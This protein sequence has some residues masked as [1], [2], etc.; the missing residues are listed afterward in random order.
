MSDIM[1]DSDIKCI[2]VLSLLF[3]YQSELSVDR[4]R[5]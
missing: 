1:N 3:F 2:I 5:L 4:I